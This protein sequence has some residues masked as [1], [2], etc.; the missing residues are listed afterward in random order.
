MLQPTIY[1]PSR[2]TKLLAPCQHLLVLHI[3]R[4][5]CRQLRQAPL[6]KAAMRLVGD[7]PQGALKRLASLGASSEFP[8]ELAAR[9]VG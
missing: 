1:I 7:K 3:L 4:T 8:V 2:A 5:E 6:E 9:R